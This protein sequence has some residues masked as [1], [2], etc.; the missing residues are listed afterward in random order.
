MSEENGGDS[1]DDRIAGTYHEAVAPYIDV[2]ELEAVGIFQRPGWLIGGGLLAAIEKLLGG[3]ARWR[4]G[5]I[6]EGRGSGGS[7]S[8]STAYVR[9]AHGSSRRPDE[10]ASRVD[11][12]PRYQDDEHLADYSPSEQERELVELAFSRGPIS[13][14][15]LSETERNSEDQRAPLRHGES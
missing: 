7:L 1:A 10:D 6:E 8:R 13:G 9:N 5:R 11:G 4:R 14:P 3:P 15:K 2:E 12:P